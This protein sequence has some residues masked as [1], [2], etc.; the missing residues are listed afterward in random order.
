MKT[1]YRISLC[2]L[3]LFPLAIFQIQSKKISYSNLEI[4]LSKNEWKKADVE[5][6]FLMGKLLS[7]SLDDKSFLG[8]SRLDFW[9]QNR[10]SLLAKKRISCNYFEEIDNLWMKYSDGKYGFSP[11]SNILNSME[12]RNKIDKNNSSIFRAFKKKVAWNYSI[13]TESKAFYNL[14]KNYK[15][16]KGYLP[17]YLWVSDNIK[18]P[19]S[20]MVLIPFLENYQKCVS[21]NTSLLR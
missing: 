9:G 19:E 17:S 20:I 3:L 7:N 2:L 13:D 10:Y 18:L 1:T 21:L 16:N 12:K 15:K 5:S 11:Q 14:S 8:Y 4:Y 6:S